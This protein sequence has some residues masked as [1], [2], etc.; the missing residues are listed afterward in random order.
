[1]EPQAENV[2]VLVAN[3]DKTFYRFKSISDKN[4]SINNV[5]KQLLCPMLNGMQTNATLKEQIKPIIF[6]LFNAFDAKDKRKCYDYLKELK[7]NEVV[8]GEIFERIS[9]KT[10][11][12]NKRTL[13]SRQVK[14]ETSVDESI[15]GTDK[16]SHDENPSQIKRKRLQIYDVNENES[17]AAS[18]NNKGINDN[19]SKDKKVICS[20][21]KSQKPVHKLPNSIIKPPDFE[22]ITFQQKTFTRKRLII[23][24]DAERKYC[25]EYFWSC[26]F[27][28]CGACEYK[29]VVVQAKVIQRNKLEVVKM[30]NNKHICEFRE[31]KPEK[32]KFDAKKQ[33]VEYPNFELVNYEEN[34]IAKTWLYIFPINDRSKCYEYS[35]CQRIKK[36]EC[37]GCINKKKRV[38]AE[39]C[40]KEDGTNFIKLGSQEHICEYRKYNPDKFTANK[41][42]ESSEFEVI[43]FYENGVSKKRLIIFGNLEKTKCYEFYWIN[44]GNFFKC[45]LCEGKDKH[46]A[47]KVEQKDDGTQF[48]RLLSPGHVCEMRDYDPE[49]YVF[50]PSKQ[51]VKKLNFKVINFEK[52]GV[53]KSMLIIFNPSNKEL[54]Y[55]Y[56]WDT[57]A[58]CYVCCGCANIKHVT[59]KICKNENGEDFVKLN[60]NEHVCVLRPYAPEKFADFLIVD[61]SGYEK[62]EYTSNG[63][64]YSKIFIFTSN[65]KE[66]CYKF[67]I[68]HG[69]KY[70]C[71]ACRRHNNQHTLAVLSKDVKGN[72][73][74][75]LSSKKHLC[76]PIK[77]NPKV[78]IL[79]PN[80]QLL[81]RKIQNR[82]VQKLI[83]FTDNDRKMCYEYRLSETYYI[84]HECHKIGKHHASANIITTGDGAECVEIGY[85]KHICKPIKFV[86]ETSVEF[87]IVKQPDF[88]L[89]EFASKKILS[90]FDKNDKTKCYTYSWRNS[91]KFFQCYPCR[92]K[93]LS[94][95][96]RIKEDENGESYVL[97]NDNEHIC[98]PKKYQPFGAK[99]V[100]L[101]NFEI[102]TE[103]K[104]GCEKQSLKIF[105]SADKSF[106]RSYFYSKKDKLFC[107][108]RCDAKRKYVSAKVKKN[109]HSEDYLELG[110]ND[111]VC[112]PYKK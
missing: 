56:F 83:V 2:K 20:T 67:C 1:M 34:G 3:F 94:V 79:L 46:T 41:I 87:K 12:L 4:L 54:C 66:F 99:I 36:Y 71:S 64:S 8:M 77:Y 92:A 103:I 21:T 100:Q 90:I 43:E 98:E 28:R 86:P 109:G 89:D 31:Y 22:I 53:S 14:I 17:F 60:K 110:I 26:N 95:V 105:V 78:R 97:L 25:Y 30:G 96:A 111:H 80:F 13:R 93:N 73:Y 32:Y 10:E 16:R 40:K 101:P 63:I 61:K 7:F 37:R 48:V 49:K 11:G 108:T 42:V 18:P 69:K 9:V 75:S 91:G 106:Y 82:I 76:E 68:N 59:A 65:S 27:F 45:G 23:F 84:C 72:E 88:K 70:Y 47:A 85:T 6:N 5:F 50:D 19:Q 38:S 33:I 51:I 81:K 39:L 102:T 58:K 52:N 62:C 15:D 44:N 112:D 29:K 57:K 74:V 24:L 55:E 107:C 35:W 104:S